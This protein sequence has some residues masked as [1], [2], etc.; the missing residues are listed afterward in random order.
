MEIMSQDISK[1]AFALSKFQAIMP[2]IPK[3]KKVKFQTKNGG[4]LDF[5]YAPLDEIIEAIKQPLASQELAYTQTGLPG[6]K[7]GLLVTTL[8]H[9]S[10]QWIRSY[11]PLDF[12][13]V[14]KEMAGDITYFKRYALNGILGL[15]TDDDN[16]AADNKAEERSREPV[17]QNGAPHKQ[18]P[19]PRHITQSEWESFDALY[20]KLSEKDRGA[21]LGFNKVSSV[22]DIPAD[23]FDSAYSWMEKA[24]AAYQ[25]KT[26]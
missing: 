8:M 6:D 11:L 9:S 12:S 5:H 23:R 17:K 15:S 21:I 14:P 2:A 7:S 22:Y 25:R 13:L 19:S 3:T 1:L 18:S 26:A 24:Y 10:G 4:M 16:D 20:Q